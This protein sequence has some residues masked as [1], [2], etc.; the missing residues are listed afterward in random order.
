MG[1][2]FFLFFFF[3]PPP[4][5]LFDWSWPTGLDCLDFNLGIMSPRCTRIESPVK[6]N[7]DREIALLRLEVFHLTCGEL[8]FVRRAVIVSQ[9]HS[10][11][12][13]KL[14]LLTSL[15]RILFVLDDRLIA[16]RHQDIS[17]FHVWGIR[18]TL[19]LRQQSAF[20]ARFIRVEI[21]WINANPTE[22]EIEKLSG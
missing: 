12:A 3:P 18:Y 22:H 10:N 19:C 4:P 6:I 20:L 11:S 1:N 21:G 9:L 16:F 17:D 14:K 15:S 7:L 13:T 2:Y 8:V 5:W